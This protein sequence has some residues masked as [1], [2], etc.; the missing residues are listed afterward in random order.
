MTAQE[1]IPK[2]VKKEAQIQL[3]EELEE[4]SLGA[5]PGTPKPVFVSS[6]LSAKK[7]E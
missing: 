7:N 3:K 1:K 4:A 6:H 2:N 5:D